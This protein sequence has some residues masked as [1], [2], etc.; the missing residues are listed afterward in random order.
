MKYAHENGCFWSK[1][2]CEYA[3]Q[4]GHLECLKYAHENGCP[5]DAFTCCIAAMNGH[6]KC[7]EYAHENGC[8]LNEMICEYTSAFAKYGSVHSKQSAQ[9]KVLCLLYASSNGCYK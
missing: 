4:N 5:W 8:P 3:A 6:F 7:L 2:T 1:K 9:S